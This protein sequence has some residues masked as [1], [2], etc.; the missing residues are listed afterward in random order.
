MQSHKLGISTKINGISCT[1]SSKV[2]RKKTAVKVNKR[3]SHS[4]CR[5][6]LCG[7]CGALYR[8]GRDEL[9]L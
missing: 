6:I 3:A 2:S 8:K 4:V 5:Y 7:R 1:T 9:Y